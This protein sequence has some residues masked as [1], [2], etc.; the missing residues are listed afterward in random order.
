MSW[1]DRLREAAYTSPLGGRAVFQYAD[2][3]REV[4]KRT[5][6]FDFP[7]VN[8][9]Y[10]QDNGHGS[11]RYPMTCYFSGANH[12]LQATTFEELLL[13][14]GVGRLEHPLYGTF[15][16][17]PFGSITRNDALATAANQSVVQVTFWTTTGAVYPSGQGNPLS[18]VV[19]S[20]VLFEDAAAAQYAEDTDLRT[21]VSKESTKATT[22][23]MLQLVGAALA[24]VSAGVTD[25][26]RD[27]RAQQQAVN[28]GMDVLIG[29]PLTLARQIVNLVT[30]PARAVVGLKLRLEAYDR[31]ATSIFGSRAGSGEQDATTLN[32]L[33]LRLSNDFH[34]SDLF[35]T[36]SVAGSIT[37]VTSHEYATRSEALTAAD[38]LAA[39]FDAAV[40]WRES[41]YGGLGQVDTGAAYQAL[42]EALALAFGY[43]ISVSFSLAAE[44]RIV[45]DRPRTIVDLAAELY[46]SV[47]DKLDFLITSNNLSGAQILE[48]SAGQSIVYYSN[49]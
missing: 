20:L 42:Q 28:L 47:D 19:G 12:D 7:L 9:A 16:V 32:S 6:A 13:D 25:V 45:L 1:E 8:N 26:N 46:G 29:Q 21:T 2:V 18:E 48:L 44:R 30:A 3:S 22:R 31:L 39:Q 23:S 37:A 17:V 10:V 5:A 36:S 15:D 24:G 35:A 14:R 33:K 38:Q 11:R 49:G 41:R 34:T 43:L 27:F 40:A 4:D